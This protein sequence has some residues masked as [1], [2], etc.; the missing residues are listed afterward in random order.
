MFTKG[1]TRPTDKSNLLYGNST[2]SGTNT[3]EDGVETYSLV[4]FVFDGSQRTRPGPPLK[5]STFY[6]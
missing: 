3:E 5:D 6:H 4:T 2:P 1:V